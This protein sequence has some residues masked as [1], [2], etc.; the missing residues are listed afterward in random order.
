[1][2]LRQP[3]FKTEGFG[4]PLYTPRLCGGCKLAPHEVRRH[5]QQKSRGDD[6]NPWV[7]L[8]FRK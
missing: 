5:A 1:V 8:E 4:D 2:R 7:A 6:R 3:N